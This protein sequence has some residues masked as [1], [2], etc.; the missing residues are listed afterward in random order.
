[1]PSVSRSNKKRKSSATEAEANIDGDLDIA[2]T[3]KTEHDYGQG[4]EDD[5]VDGEG[6][7]SIADMDIDP[8]LL[9]IGGLEAMQEDEQIGPNTVPDIHEDI[10]IEMAD[11]SASPAVNGT[12]A[13]Q[14]KGPTTPSISVPTFELPSIPSGS[15]STSRRKSSSTGKRPK[16][17]ESR[18]PEIESN[19][20]RRKTSN[21]AS[22]SMSMSPIMEG[23]SKKRKDSGL[24]KSP[25]TPG[26]SSSAGIG[27][28]TP[29]DSGM[30]EEEK[31]SLQLA[32]QLQA[33]EFGLRGRRSGGSGSG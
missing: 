6:E 5:E 9:A 12:D 8:A 28:V 22:V 14:K 29:D 31:A 21:T 1:M 3:V 19:Q 26:A 30:T 16:S 17:L 32:I 7:F 10:D 13:T 33:Q 25:T 2:H 18:T 24:Q 15:R 11:V 23:S 20:L 4:E 27:L